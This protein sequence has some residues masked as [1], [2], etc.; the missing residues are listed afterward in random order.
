MPTQS[1]LPSDLAT[2]AEREACELSDSRWDY[3]VGRLAEAIRTNFPSR[4]HRAAQN[5]LSF[6]ERNRR[7]ILWVGFGGCAATALILEV[8]Q[9][10]EHE[11]SEPTPARLRKVSP[12]REQEPKSSPDYSQSPA[13]QPGSA[14]TFDGGGKPIFHNTAPLQPRKDLIREVR[15]LQETN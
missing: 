10:T 2:L 7:W 6:V 12:S 15:L 5:G 4:F 13:T 9:F 11:S 1:E 8:V 14:Q 3:D